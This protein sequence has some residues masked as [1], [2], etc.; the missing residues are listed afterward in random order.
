MPADFASGVGEGKAH[1]LGRGHALSDRARDDRDEF[2]TAE[3][4][5]HVVLAH[6][7]A[8]DRAE[9]AQRLIADRVSVAVIDR[10]EMVEVEHQHAHPPAA[11][12]L[13]RHHLAGRLEES[14]AVEQAGH[15]IGQRGLLVDA[16]G[17]LLGQH[18]HDEGG[19]HDIEHDFERE[20]RDPPAR[21]RDDAAL[22]GKHAG[23]RN[24]K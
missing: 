22:G 19:P 1:P 9:Q 17:A 24:R 7:G 14:A 16:D 12:G 6:R 4:S 3:A 5:D 2:L 11:L 23:Q 18:Q 8:G 21:E 15:R 20:Q 13:P 10:L